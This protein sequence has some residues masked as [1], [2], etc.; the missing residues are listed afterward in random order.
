MKLLV[1][2][3]MEVILDVEDVQHVRAED[4]TGV[5]GILPGHADFITV[6]TVSVLTWRNHSNE[7]HHLVVR[8][9]VLT[10]RDGTLVEVA[11]REAISCTDSQT[12]CWNNFDRRRKRRK[13][14]GFLPPGCI[15]RPSGNSSTIS[16]RG[17]NRFQERCRRL[18]QHGRGTVCPRRARSD[19]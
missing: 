15:W 5:F 2:T 12:R 6:L 7:E 18:A 3:P 8:G 17:T 19:G 9:G 11:T 14:P 4:E 16:S 13:C 1:T 10:V